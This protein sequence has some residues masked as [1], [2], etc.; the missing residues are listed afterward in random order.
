M[1]RS[2]LV[3]K[4]AAG[5]DSKSFSLTVKD[6]DDIV[7][8]FFNKISQA[9]AAGD[10]VEIRGFGTFSVRERKPRTAVNPK[11]KS[12]VT[13]PAKKAVHFKTGRELH[14]RLNG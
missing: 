12:K 6:I 14:C 8:V 7:D 11:T 10:R 5:M 3:E 9:M 13:V 2:E 1:T 4:I